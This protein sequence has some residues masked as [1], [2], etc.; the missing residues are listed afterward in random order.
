MTTKPKFKIADLRAARNRVDWI[1]NDFSG[2]S[3]RE[4]MSRDFASVISEAYAALASMIAAT[5]SRFSEDAATAQGALDRCAVS[6]YRWALARCNWEAMSQD[7]QDAVVMYTEIAGP[8]IRAEELAPET[9]DKLR[10]VVCA[11]FERGYTVVTPATTTTVH[12]AEELPP[13]CVPFRKMA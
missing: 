3:L 5:P 10:K 2:G 13:N 7:Q 9:M 8:Y 4:C 11:I 6:L 12:E 1:R